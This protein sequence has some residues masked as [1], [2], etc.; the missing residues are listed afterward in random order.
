MSKLLE[1]GSSPNNS[2]SRKEGYSG[3]TPLML[4]AGARL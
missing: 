3:Y 2:N 4:A 1:L